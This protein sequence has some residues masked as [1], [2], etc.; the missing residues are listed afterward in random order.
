MFNHPII[1][2]LNQKK[3]INKNKELEIYEFFEN[4]IN[5]LVI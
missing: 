2:V 1:N 3:P 4:S 5:C